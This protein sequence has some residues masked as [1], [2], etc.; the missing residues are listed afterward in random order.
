MVFLGWIYVMGGGLDF[1]NILCFC[2]IY[3]LSRNKWIYGKG[4]WNFVLNILVLEVINFL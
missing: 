4:K 3:E 2:E 1:C